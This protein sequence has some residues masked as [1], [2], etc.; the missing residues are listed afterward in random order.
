LLKKGKKFSWS[1]EC[2]SA[3]EKIKSILL[4]APVLMAADFQK[5]FKLF[6]DAGD[7]DLGAA[8]FQEDSYGVDHPMCYYSKKLNYHQQNYFTSEKETLALLLSLQHF[9]VYVDLLFLLLRSLLTTTP[10][11]HKCDC[12]SENQSS[13]HNY[14]YLEIPI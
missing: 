5:Q 8:L 2:H 11:I 14:K 9:D 3:F 12:L 1:P 7:V 10:S 6:M 4:S 13:L